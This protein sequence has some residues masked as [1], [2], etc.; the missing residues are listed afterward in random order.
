MAGPNGPA[1][2]VWVDMTIRGLSE[3]MAYITTD[4]LRATP[5]FTMTDQ[6][7]QP[8]LRMGN[9]EVRL[10]DSEVEVDAAQALRYRVFYTEMAAPPAPERAA[11]R[12]DF[13]RFDELCDRLL[14]I[15]HNRGPG[16]DAVIGT[17]RLIRRAAAA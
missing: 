13:D 2:R 5:R 6:L 14:V 1:D 4:Q 3:S 12:R 9:L 11:G 7:S 15:D 16:P 10:A 8:D 17:Y